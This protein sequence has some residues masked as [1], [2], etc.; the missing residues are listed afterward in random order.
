MSTIRSGLRRTFMIEADR[1]PNPRLHPDRREQKGAAAYFEGCWRRAAQERRVGFDFTAGVA[2]EA[3]EQTFPSPESERV[4]AILP[5]SPPPS[6][7]V[8]SG[9]SPPAESPNVD[10]RHLPGLFRAA[11]RPGRRG[12]QAGPLPPVRRRDARARVAARGGLRGGGRTRTA[13]E[14]DPRGE[15]RR[16]PR[17]RGRPPA[18]ETEAG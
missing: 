9:N 1:R 7:A 4:R 2:T 6:P 10:R 8:H 13:Q 12:R 14:A 17:R 15:V 3:I 16:A 5:S 11:Q 18:Q